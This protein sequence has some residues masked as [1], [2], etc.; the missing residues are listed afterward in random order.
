MLF[1]SAC[2]TLKALGRW[3]SY[4]SDLGLPF[5]EQSWQRSKVVKTLTKVLEAWN[6]GPLLGSPGTWQ[7]PEGTWSI[8]ASPKDQSKSAH[9][10]RQSWR[11]S[12]FLGWFTSNRRDASVA[13]AERLL[14]THALVQKLRSVCSGLSGNS[15]AVACGGCSTDARW[16]FWGPQRT[17]CADCLEAEAPT[18]EHIFWHCKCEAYVGLRSIPKPRSRLRARLGWSS[19]PLPKSEEQALLRQLGALRSADGDNA[20]PLGK[21]T[22][23]AKLFLP[24]LERVLRT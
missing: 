14:P 6:W 23:G 19:T 11:M 1:I 7:A 8:F 20:V 3:A 17:R 15:I 5:S 12:Q 21:V 16:K 10:F 9:D 4:V 24:Q 2:R 18:V 22:A 13:R